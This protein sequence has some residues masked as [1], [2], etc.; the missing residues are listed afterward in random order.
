[1][2]KVNLVCR[3]AALSLALVVWW[4][5]GMA[6]A[7]PATPNQVLIDAVTSNPADAPRLAAQEIAAGGPDSAPPIVS[8]VVRVLPRDLRLSLA[9]RVV[10]AAIAALPARQR[11]PQAPA[12]ACAAIGAVPADEQAAVVVPIVAAAAA[13]APTASPRIVACATDAVPASAAAIIAAAGLASVQPEVLSTPTAPQPATSIGRDV[14]LQ[15]QPRQTVICA[16][17]PCP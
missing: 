12:I 11:A 2:L 6:P 8:D 3:A 7:Q 4:A 17:P 16:S 10:S 5:P 15:T 14:L 13:M 1:M 9:P